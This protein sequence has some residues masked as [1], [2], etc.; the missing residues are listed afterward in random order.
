MILRSTPPRQSWDIQMTTSTHP[1]TPC[2]P[3]NAR[4]PSGG[5][6]Y[7]V[8]PLPSPYSL[9]PGTVDWQVCECVGGTFP[10]RRS[11]LDIR[12]PLKP[13]HPVAGR[14]GAQACGAESTVWTQGCRSGQTQ[15][16]SPHGFRPTQKGPER[17]LPFQMHW[18]GRVWG[19]G[20]QEASLRLQD[21]TPSDN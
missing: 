14:E 18:G 7:L 9:S 20:Q 3:L 13:I 5:L 11:P 10:G 8:L 12:L 21:Q 1:V 6:T 15:P 19:G 17:E 4:E 2:Q 16:L